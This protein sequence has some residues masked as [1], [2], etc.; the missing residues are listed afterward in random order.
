MDQEFKNITFEIRSRFSRIP[1]TVKNSVPYV[2]Q[3]ARPEH[4]ELSLKGELLPINDPDWRNTGA[5]SPERYAQWAFTM[6][7][8]ACTAMTLAYFKN[9]TYLPAV[10]AE[11]ALKH[12]VYHETVDEISS[13]RYAEYAQWIGV[14]AL[15]ARVCTRLSIRGIRFALANGGLVIASVNP[16]IRGYDT[17]PAHQ[18]G[19]HLVVVTGYDVGKDAVSLN[20]PSGFVSTNTQAGHTVST[21]EFMRY[22]AGRGIVVMKNDGSSTVDSFV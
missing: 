15:S 13:M 9:R 10:L 22:F 12:N 17:V 8:M 20:N 21:D 7:G 11:D 5:S 4:A 2:C 19:G 3:F 1:T 18:K 16:N 6:C 14:Y